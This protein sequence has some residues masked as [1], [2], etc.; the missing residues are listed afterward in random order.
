MKILKKFLKLQ[1]ILF[2][3]IVFI[4][5]GF[6]IYAKTS[7]KILINSANNITLLD[8]QGDVFFTGSENQEWVSLE[9]ISPYV[10]SATIHT[11]DKYFYK[12]FG[13]DFLRIGKAMIHNILTKS[14]SQGASTITQQYAKNLF[15]DFDKTWKRKFDEALYTIKIEAN[16]SK[17]EILE[18][19]LNTINY[20]HG[21]YG[22][23]SASQFYFNK[24]CKDLDLAEASILV[25]IPKA[26]SNYSPLINY[27]ASKNRQLVVLNSLVRDGIITEREKM[28]AYDEEL[29]FV[30]EEEINSLTSINYYQDALMDELESIP[31]IPKDYS[32]IGG[33]KVY[34]TFHY[35]LQKNLDEIIKSTFPDESNLETSVVVMDPHTGGIMAL[36]GGKDYN[37]S[38][39]NRAIYSKRQVG[40]TMKPYLYYA[41]LENG[42][43][44]S[45]AFISERTTFPLEDGK[46]Y[47]P[48]NYNDIYGDKAI[49]MA[50]AIAYSDNIYAVKTHLFLGTDTLIQMAKRVGIKEKLDEVPSLPLGTSEINIVSMAAGYSSFANMGYRVNSHIIERVEDGNGNVLYE[51]PHTKDLVLNPSL[52]YILNNMLTAP[53]DSS[54]IDYNYPTAINLANKLTHT[55][56][57]K[58]GTTSGDN[59][60][61]GFNS[62][63][64][65]AVWV[66]YDDNTEL[67]KSDYKYAQNIWYKTV[68]S[69]ED[70]KEDFWYEK[71][72]NVVG[73]LVDPITGRPANQNS[74]NV[75]LMY[76][77]KGTE[78]KGD[79]PVFDEIEKN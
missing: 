71:P 38:S 47:S 31:T 74:Q 53:Y 65:C 10:I 32:K 64:L 2:I 34:T 37:K 40:S 22:I 36:V 6:Y 26:P 73:V 16:Y 61:I 14:T 12:H 11:E 46:T 15:L 18:G 50:T 17:D 66:G 19:Y 68:E 58:S 33:L 79:E 23:E 35:D 69:F 28:L 3:I 72:S 4:G 25:G 49:S 59:W 39:Y 78:P 8:Y 55:Y 67:V 21:N 54:Y 41:A 75:K 70:G 63:V 45:T 30:G 48:H 76:F 52:V 56:A 24:S 5:I 7:P 1:F 29:V 57:L 62:D 27:D 42:F 51:D 13:F 9:D 77:L 60:N 44:S 20:G 43:T